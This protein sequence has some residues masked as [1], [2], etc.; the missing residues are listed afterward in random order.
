MFLLSSILPLEGCG[1]LATK[2]SAVFLITLSGSKVKLIFE[3]LIL[4][5]F[6]GPY[7]IHLLSLLNETMTSIAYP[8]LYEFERISYTTHSI[9]REKEVII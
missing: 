9:N 4:G 7:H 8:K 6:L 1:K 5:A 2:C 3:L